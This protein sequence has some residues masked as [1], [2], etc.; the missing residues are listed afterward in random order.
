V[1][2]ELWG[3]IVKALEIKAVGLKPGGRMSQNRGYFPALWPWLTSLS[4]GSRQD[5]ICTLPGHL[6][7]S[8][9]IF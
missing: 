5:A 1:V 7:L 8:C 4:I 9:P 3:F 6:R 2:G